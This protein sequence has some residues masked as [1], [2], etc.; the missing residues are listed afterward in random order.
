LQI[1]PVGL[2][3]WVTL[4]ALALTVFLAIEIHKWTWA[5]RHRELLDATV[6]NAREN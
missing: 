2:T 1:Q 5:L 6:G 4:L 3:T